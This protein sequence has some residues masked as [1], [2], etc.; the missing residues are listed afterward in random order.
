MI[1]K[2]FR[3]CKDETYINCVLSK[4][5]ISSLTYINAENNNL[6]LSLIRRVPKVSRP[7]STE[8][9]WRYH[10]ELVTVS[11]TDKE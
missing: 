8:F 4:T 7:A 1:D 10:L 9:P 2:R 11:E 5:E 6:H 3:I